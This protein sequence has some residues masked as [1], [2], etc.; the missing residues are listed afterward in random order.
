MGVIAADVFTLDGLSP[1]TVLAPTT[2]EEVAAAIREADA[3][4]EAIVLWG[5]GTRVS[6]GDPPERY[7]VALDL[8][9]LR[10]VVAQEPADMT[11][12]V[13]AGTTLA[14]LAAALAPHGQRW[15]VEVGH[16]ERATVGG[17]VASA[18]DGPARLRYFHPRDW[19]I[20]VQAALGDGTLTRA[21]GRVVKNVTGYDLTRLYSGTYGT[22]CA[23]CELTLKVTA[24]PE[25]T[26][27][28]R[29]DLPHPDFAYQ[30]IREL[31]LR[32]LPLDALALV[33]GPHAEAL[34]SPTQLG[35]FVRVAGAPAVVDRLVAELEA[36]LP[37]VPASDDVWARIAALQDDATF[38][39][40]ASWA[41]GQRVNVYPGSAV[42]YPGVDS[43]HVFDEQNA[44]QARA[45]RAAIAERGGA[46]TLERAPAELKR[47]VGAWGPSRAP[48]A[49]VRALK[50]RFD[51]R[52]VL[53]PGRMTLG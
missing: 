25:R 16:P 3:A 43:L 19:T 22:L 49:I 12:T 27:S 17:T 24:L 37:L 9:G 46:V 14:E 7:D 50:E 51:P 23:L 47:A 26:R 31:L 1:R 10:G 15:P 42:L 35:L 41:P 18:A 45:F 33:I 38:A 29:A 5:G 44:D 11:I 21:G 13:R 52:G 20:G 2:A 32:R 8:R 28:L 53:A 36:E 4:G 6:I 40:R 48:A 30:R 39:I 34:G